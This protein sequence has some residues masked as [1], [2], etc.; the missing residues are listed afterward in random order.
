MKIT[1]YTDGGSRG[2]PGPA[3]A[4][5]VVFDGE[6]NVLAE[7]SD[8]LGTT[9]NNV[10]E[11]E[12]LERALMATRDWLANN[13]PHPNPL[14][15]KGEGAAQSPNTKVHIE[16]RMDSEL[17][18]KQMLGIYRVKDSKMKE[19]FMRIG[20]LR[21][22]LPAITFTHVRREFNKHADRLVNEAI[23]RALAERRNGVK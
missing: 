10:A 16:V 22:N 12:A 2:N 14:P 15:G 1:L 23:D 5:A 17:I 7:I 4:G 6:G 11:Y 19:F 3:A 20:M 9:T 8:F 13:P 18:I 21:E